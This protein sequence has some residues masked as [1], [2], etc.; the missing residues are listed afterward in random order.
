M[1]GPCPADRLRGNEVQ[2]MFRCDTVLYTRV[3]THV[4]EHVVEVPLANQIANPI[5]QKKK[6][7]KLINYHHPLPILYPGC[8][9]LPAPWTALHGRF[10]T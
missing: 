2:F 8:R 5:V 9:A 6:N 4:E 10:C 3:E 7:R 1:F